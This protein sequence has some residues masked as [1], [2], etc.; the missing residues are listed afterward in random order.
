MTEFHYK[1]LN[2]AQQSAR[3]AGEVLLQHFGLVTVHEKESTQNIVTAADV[4]SEQRITQLI[5]DAFPQH[6]LLR[7]ETVFEGDLMADQLWVVDPLDATN[8]YAHGIPH[9]C[10][11]IAFVQR[12]SP[13][14]GVV[15]DPMRDEMFWAVRGEGAWLNG[16][17]IR[18]AQPADLSRSIIATGFYY[19]RGPMMERTLDSIRVLFR[20]NIRGLRRMG[21]AAL[22]LSWTA[23]GRFQG[24]F[25]YQLAPW[26]YAAGW[27][28]VEEAGG[29]CWDR[30][31]R[32]M[33]LEARSVMAACPAIGEEFVRLVA[34]PDE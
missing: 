1:V 17:S 13:Q 10:V 33:R 7:E 12:G 27:L 20:R 5:L 29:N 8:N 19:D 9:F 26:D 11:S 34:W 2:V 23:C 6:S 28:L 30:A 21:G 15:Y 18:V 24:Y 32:P 3:A 22:D 16:R 4:A 14:V 25:E 31:G